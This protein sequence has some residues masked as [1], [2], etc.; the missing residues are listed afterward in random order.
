MEG[1]QDGYPV[2]V[3]A[4]ISER[5][6]QQ[7]LQYIRDGGFLNREATDTLTLKMVLYNPAAVVFGYYSAVL[8]WLASGHILMTITLQVVR[9]ASEYP[10]HHYTF[11]ASRGLK[12]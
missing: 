9:D 4:A 8:E 2:L 3:S 11:D 1:L 7:T 6:A 12:P 5:R 10:F